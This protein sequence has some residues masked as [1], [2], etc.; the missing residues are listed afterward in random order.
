M[1]TFQWFCLIY[2]SLA[3][4]IF[5]VAVWL[6]DITRAKNFPDFCRALGLA[7]IAGLAWPVTAGLSIWGLIKSDEDEFADGS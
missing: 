6:F 5:A 2:L 4:V 3:V 7:I 1:T